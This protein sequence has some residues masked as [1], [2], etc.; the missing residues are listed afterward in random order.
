MKSQRS[1]CVW[2]SNKNQ[3]ISEEGGINKQKYKAEWAQIEYL[4]LLCVCHVSTGLQESN[5]KWQRCQIFQCPL[6]GEL[7]IH[8]CTV[9]RCRHL[10]AAQ[11]KPDNHMTVERR[12]EDRGEKERLRI[13]V[14]TCLRQDGEMWPSVLYGCKEIHACDIYLEVIFK[15]NAYSSILTFQAVI[16]SICYQ[17]VGYETSFMS[18]YVNFY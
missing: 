16:F 14:G 11:E 12:A 17:K 10:R 7:F 3:I 9:T 6:G 5:C 8:I 4:L 13:D 18:F 2:L 1:L 15:A